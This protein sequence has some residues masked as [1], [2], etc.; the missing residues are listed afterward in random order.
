MNTAKIY[1]FNDDWKAAGSK[2]AEGVSRIISDGWLMYYNFREGA[3]EDEKFNPLTAITL[4]GWSFGVNLI[5][6]YFF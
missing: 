6:E 2:S 3:N 1:Y 5:T 4:S